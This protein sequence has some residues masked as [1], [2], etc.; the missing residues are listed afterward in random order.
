MR[1]CVY[2]EF[3]RVNVIGTLTFEKCFQ[4]VVAAVVL[5]SRTKLVK[6][7]FQAVVAAVLRKAAGALKLVDLHGHRTKN[8]NTSSSPA[9]EACCR[10][11]AREGGREEGREEGEAGGEEMNEEAQEE[12]ASIRDAVWALRDLKKVRGFTTW[13]PPTPSADAVCASPPL[14]PE[15]ML[16]PKECEVKRMP[17]KKSGYKKIKENSQLQAATH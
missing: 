13:S 12:E 2:N 8:R 16:P 5:V 3:C 14:P 7:C 15:T 9:R 6:N 4:A 17:Q 1:V 10:E 11:E